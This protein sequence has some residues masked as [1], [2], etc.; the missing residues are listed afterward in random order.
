M[1][2]TYPFGRRF[3][4]SCPPQPR[5]L[6]GSSVVERPIWAYS[7]STPRARWC[8]QRLVAVA[9]FQA[10]LALRERPDRATTLRRPTTPPPTTAR[11]VWRFRVGDF[12]M[13]LN[14]L[15]RL[16]HGGKPT[17]GFLL[18]STNP[19]PS[20]RGARHSAKPCDRIHPAAWIGSVAFIARTI[21]SDHRWRHSARLLFHG[22][23]AVLPVNFLSVVWWCR[24][25][26]CLAVEFEDGLVF[27]FVAE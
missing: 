6:A 21:R 7:Q 8:A 22:E 18:A 11:G 12:G 17:H 25:P 4:N 15:E 13:N 2:A 14:R 26:F 10:A 1:F 9:A 3:L 16:G 5:R 27:L 23:L 19:V 24:N 20:R